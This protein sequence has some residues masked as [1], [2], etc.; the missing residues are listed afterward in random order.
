MNIWA[1][2]KDNAIKSLLLQLESH[3]QEGKYLLVDRAEDDFRSIRLMGLETS[4]IELYIYCFGQ[5]ED[6]YGVHIEYPNLN[7]TNFSD[8][9]EIHEDLSF[10]QLSN[11]IAVNFGSV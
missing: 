9:L 7:D 6:H 5:S 8:T 10:D 4:D 3:F 1:L 11:L 2:N